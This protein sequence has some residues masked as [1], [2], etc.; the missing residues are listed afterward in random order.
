MSEVFSGE[1]SAA[2][3]FGA[4]SGAGLFARRPRGPAP[5]NDPAANKKAQ[6]RHDLAGRRI[7]P[8]ELRL[9]RAF[10][11]EPG[12][13]NK[14]L[15]GRL[16]LSPRTVESHL[17][18][19]RA[20]LAAKSK[21]EALRAFLRWRRLNEPA[22]IR[23]RVEAAEAAISDILAELQRDLGRPVAFAGLDGGAAERAPM[24]VLQEEAEHGR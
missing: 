13:L 22:E 19:L 20:K 18:K 9:L 17:H 6:R 15:A 11:T 24:I 16:G 14:Q 3:G 10:E 7:S 8:A 2:S 23:A 5:A 12:A 1:F 21:E 4:P